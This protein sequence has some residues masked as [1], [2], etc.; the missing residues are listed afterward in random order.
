MGRSY[1]DRTF[2]GDKEQYLPGEGNANLKLA[3]QRHTKDAEALPGWKNF[4]H[5]PGG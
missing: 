2:S 1:R 3:I 4:Y 5:F